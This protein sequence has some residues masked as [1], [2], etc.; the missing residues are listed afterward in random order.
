MSDI[1]INSSNGLRSDLKV[2]GENNIDTSSARGGQVFR[3]IR[4]LRRDVELFKQELMNINK[5]KID[6]S[7]YAPDRATVDKRKIHK[8]PGEEDWQHVP[9]QSES[10][11][12]AS[13]TLKY[14]L[15]KLDIL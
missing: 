1:K 13:V 11:E 3:E 12:V 5:V 7:P 10:S 9:V 15:K 2:K 4:M 8:N 6:D 14:N